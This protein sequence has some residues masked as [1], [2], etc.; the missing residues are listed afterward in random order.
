MSNID[1]IDHENEQSLDQELNTDQLFTVSGAITY[2]V[3][4][5]MASDKDALIAF[6]TYMVLLTLM[7][8]CSSQISI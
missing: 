4:H 2:L 8:L 7:T 5:V 3:N 1:D 6:L